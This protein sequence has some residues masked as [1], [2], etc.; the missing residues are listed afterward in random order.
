[1]IILSRFLSIRKR[2]IPVV[3]QPAVYMTPDC[4]FSLTV[5]WNM[6]ESEFLIHPDTVYINIVLSNKMQPKQASFSFVSSG[7]TDQSRLFIFLQGHWVAAEISGQRK[8][9]RCQRL[10]YSFGQLHNP[11]RLS[12]CH[13]QQERVTASFAWEAS[14]Q[15]HLSA[16]R[17]CLMNSN[18]FRIFL[19]NFIFFK[20]SS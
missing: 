19:Y 20:L 7:R 13:V 5:L 9:T 10:Y 3:Y 14:C 12:I 17:P 4:F 16:F 8:C 11:P 6:N 18:T 1:M 15:D 2:D